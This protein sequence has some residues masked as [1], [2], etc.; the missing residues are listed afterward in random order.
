M[1]SNM[2]RAGREQPN[3]GG[4]LQQRLSREADHHGWQFACEGTRRAAKTFAYPS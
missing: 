1:G 3:L 2:W 4:F